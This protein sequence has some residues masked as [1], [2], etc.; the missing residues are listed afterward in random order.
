VK[1]LEEKILS[2]GHILNND[3]I[4]VDSFIN[5][6]VDVVLVNNIG[7]FF[8]S[9]F[10]NIDKVLTLET[11]GIIFGLVTAQALGNVPLVYAKKNK[12]AIINENHSYISNV[13]SFTHNV[14][15][16]ISV[17]KDYINK[18][19]RVLIVDDFLANGSAA[20]GLV[21]IIEQAGAIP[22][23]FCTA[24]EKYFQPGRKLL[25]DKGL[26]VVA[27]AKIKAFE[28]NVPIFLED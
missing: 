9:K 18:G 20:T 27:A 3:I 15:N 17:N 5:H 23:G 25:E 16:M 14:D 8:A 24:I 10:Q 12:S 21:D 11:S 1:E 6:K 26:K 4:K 22:V 7:K 2:E 28:N 13:H 19:E